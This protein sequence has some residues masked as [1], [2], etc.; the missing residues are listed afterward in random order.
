M[1]RY[2]SII[3]YISGVENEKQRIREVETFV[4]G[5]ASIKLFDLNDTAIFP[6]V[7][8]RFVYAGSF[9]YFPLNEF[10]THLQEKVNWDYPESI[11]LLVEEE[12]KACCSF[13]VEAGAKLI[14]ESKLF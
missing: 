2:T 4:F 13:Y 9:N 6:D 7:F 5:N 3:L 12:G 1:S 8:P 14:Y 10:L 11:Q